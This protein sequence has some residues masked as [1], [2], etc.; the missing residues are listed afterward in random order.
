M[1]A[2]ARRTST[3]QTPANKHFTLTEFVQLSQSQRES[4][5][6]GIGVLWLKLFTDL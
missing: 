2:A 3:S 6:Q 1:C 4:A 5:R